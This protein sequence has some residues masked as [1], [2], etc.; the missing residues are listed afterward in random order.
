[1]A[2]WP[3]KTNYATGDVLT[4]AQMQDIGNALNSLESAQYAAGKN[5]I[6]NGDFALNQRSFTSTTSANTFGFDRW[7]YTFST[8]TITYSAQTFTPGT[9]PVSGYESANFARVQTSG[10][11]ATSSYAIFIQRIENVRTL[12]GQTATISFWAK[13]ASGTPKVAV[14]IEQNFGAGGSPSSAVQTYAGQVTLSTSW[15]RYSVTVAIPSISGKTVGTTA[16]SSFIQLAL[17]ITAGSDFNSRT[18]SIGI[19]TNTF[20][21]WGVQVEAG[22]SATPF[23]T[24]TGTIQGELAACQRYYYRHTAGTVYANFGQGNARSTTNT[25]ALITFPVPMRVTPTSLDS[26]TASNYRVFDGQTATT[27]TTLALE[28]QTDSFTGIVYTTVASGLTATRNYTLDA[29]NTTSAYIG[30]SAEL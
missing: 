9:A 20:D 18:G 10:Q 16:N 5:K 27:C 26:G 2:T 30:F 21:F 3:A 17:W 28:G 7:W 29:N 25:A 23:A 12:A 8:G 11:S 4:A 1:M 14:E 24:A 22:N 19:Q 6:I 15:A 13:A